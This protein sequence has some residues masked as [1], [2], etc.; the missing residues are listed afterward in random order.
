VEGSDCSFDTALVPHPVGDSVCCLDGRWLEESLYS[1]CQGGSVK[2]FAVEGA[3]TSAGGEDHVGP[4]RLTG[5]VS[6]GVWLR[7]SDGLTLRKRGRWL[8]GGR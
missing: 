8:L 2:G 7:G 6:F 5:L 3:G 1:S 4:E